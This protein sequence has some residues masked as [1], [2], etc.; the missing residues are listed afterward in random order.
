MLIRDLIFDYLGIE[1]Y[2]F[3]IRNWINIQMKT[4]V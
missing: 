1:K 4:C 3:V 2:S